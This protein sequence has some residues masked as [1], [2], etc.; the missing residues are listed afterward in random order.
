MVTTVGSLEVVYV[1]VRVE[2][3]FSF[4]FKICRMFGMFSMVKSWPGDGCLHVSIISVDLIYGI[5]DWMFSGF[6]ESLE[7]LVC[8][9]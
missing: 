6:W 4:F 7:C 1:A 5:Q 9:N 2:C 8:H 3:L